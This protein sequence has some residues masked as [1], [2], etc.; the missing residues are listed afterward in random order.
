[1]THL[2]HFVTPDEDVLFL[3]R[4]MYKANYKICSVN[5][6]LEITLSE[7]NKAVCQLKLGGSGSSDFFINEFLYYG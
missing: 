5:W 2:V 7:I 6:I 1:M 3:M 4:D